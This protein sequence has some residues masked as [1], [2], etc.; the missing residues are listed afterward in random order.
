MS[1]AENWQ[2]GHKMKMKNKQTNMYSPQ[3]SLLSSGEIGMQA[4]N[5]NLL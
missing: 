3:G 4:N 5:Y 1:Q 2:T